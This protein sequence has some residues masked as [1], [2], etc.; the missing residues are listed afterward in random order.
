MFERD[1]VQDVGGHMDLDCRCDIDNRGVIC[2]GVQCKLN[3]WWA[4]KLRVSRST[5]VLA[6][7]VI[8]IC[9]AHFGKPPPTLYINIVH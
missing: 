1:F 9:H 5:R 2:D 3:S 7:S 4:T 6:H 8:V